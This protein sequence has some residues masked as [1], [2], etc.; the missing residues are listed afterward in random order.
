MKS[1]YLCVPYHGTA[2]VEGAPKEGIFVYTSDDMI[3]PDTWNECMR[4]IRL[5]LFCQH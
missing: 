5:H 2:T 4:N 1:R 3:D